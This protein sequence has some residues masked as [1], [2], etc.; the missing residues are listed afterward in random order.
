MTPT[1]IKDIRKKLGVS[2]EKLAQML[3]VTF[4]TVNRWERG[5]CKPSNLALD[6]MK[7]LTETKEKT[8]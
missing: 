7:L 8:R 1:E 6:K 4:G 2:Q 5:T 3:G